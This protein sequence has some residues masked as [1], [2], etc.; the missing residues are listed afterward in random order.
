M[1]ELLKLFLVFFKI[2]VFTVGGG[3]AMIPFVQKEAVEVHKWISPTFFSEIIALDTVTPGPLAVNLATFVGYKV[4]GVLGAVIAT[5]G[6]V[7]PSLIIVTVIASLYFVF[8]ENKAFQ[9]VMQGLKPAV[10]ALIIAA[11][12][13]LLQAKSITDIRGLGIALV[14]LVGVVW[15]RINPIYLVSLSAIAG[16]V[17]YR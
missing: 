4:N 11:V 7:L 14:V 6:V 16:Y 3:Y 15:F 10:V 1:P 9:A 5:L 2:G 13:H 17:L 12:V 8:R